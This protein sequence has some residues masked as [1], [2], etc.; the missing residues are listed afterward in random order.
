MFNVQDENRTTKP[1]SIAIFP[2]GSDRLY[3]VP[4]L[5]SK[6]QCCMAEW[7]L[8]TQHQEGKEGIDN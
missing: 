8:R 7:Q 6:F 5:N 4:P 2:K 1:R 3:T